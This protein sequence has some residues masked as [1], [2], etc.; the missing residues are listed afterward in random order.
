MFDYIAANTW[1]FLIIVG[2]FSLLIGSFLNVVVHRLPIMLE[3]NWRKQCIDYLNESSDFDNP[4]TQYNLAFP[5]SHCPFCYTRLAL[6]QNIPI[7][8][9]IILKGRCAT[10]KKAIPLRYLLIEICSL[11]LSIV[12]AIQFGIS[13]EL[14]AALVL[15][16]FLVTISFI[17]I[18]HQILPDLLTI[19]LL[20]LGLLLSCFNLFANSHDSILGVILGYAFFWL[21]DKLFKLITRK[22]GIGE[23][24]FKLLAAS[25]AWLGWQLLPFVILFSSILGLIVGSSILFIQKKPRGTSIPYG[26]FI[27][28]AIWIG[29]IWGYDITQS[30]LQLFGISWS[31]V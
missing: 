8:S 6:W 17:D 22:E 11:V 27:A 10:C 18:D 13:Y 7:V 3:R 26:P 21:I 31:N 9:Y 19:P 2:L 30:Y 12:A 5:A 4:V 24:D 20:W 14:L 15:T 25:G 23:G 28:I 29:I 1:L 16:W